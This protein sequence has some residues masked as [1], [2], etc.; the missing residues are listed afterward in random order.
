[1]N[2]VG[3]NDE[4]IFDG[5]SLAVNRQGELLAI[6]AGF[7]EDIRTFDLDTPGPAITYCPEDEI[8]SVY[9]ALVLGLRDY[10][11]KSGF[12]GHCGFVRGIDSSLTACLAV[13]A[14]GRTTYWVSSCLHPIPRQKP[15]GCPG[16]GTK[17]GH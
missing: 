7:K 14:L 13:A 9:H 6:G 1:M 8:A 2:R 10:V 11:H 12:P 16:S 5:H 17:P 4:L 3:G 15:A